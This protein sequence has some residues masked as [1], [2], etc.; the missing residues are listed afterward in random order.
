MGN[1][2]RAGGL[3]ARR[4]NK[5]NTERKKEGRKA[6]TLIIK[7][8]SSYTTL[9]HTPFRVSSLECAVLADAIG[10]VIDFEWRT[11]QKCLREIFFFP[12]ENETHMRLGAGSLMRYN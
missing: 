12:S 2:G 10:A 7:R 3:V 8:K 11:C 4:R 5:R 6:Q 1:G 9:L